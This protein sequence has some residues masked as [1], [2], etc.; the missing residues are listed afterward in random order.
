MQASEEVALTA[1]VAVRAT[2]EVKAA[3]MARREAATRAA[4]WVTALAA[5]AARES[6]A[7]L[8]TA[9]QLWI[10]AIDQKESV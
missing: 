2:S 8:V 6:D 4:A 3:A 9:C 1:H 7:V 10:D 5:A